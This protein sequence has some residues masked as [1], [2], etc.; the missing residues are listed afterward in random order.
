M[1]EIHK[2]SFTEGLEKPKKNSEVNLL[3]FFW[4]IIVGLHAI[5]MPVL[6][7]S[8]ASK[9]YVAMGLYGYLLIRI[10][11]LWLKPEKISGCRLFTWTIL[12]APVWFETIWFFVVESRL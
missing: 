8:G 2:K 4:F 1:K 11:S 5:F 6:C 12:T 3:F 10:F 7:F 9:K